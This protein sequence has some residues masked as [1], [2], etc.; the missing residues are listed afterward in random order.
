MAS[1]R[2]SRSLLLLVK[3]NQILQVFATDPHSII[4]FKAYCARTGNKLI[5]I[6]ELYDKNLFVFFIQRKEITSL[7]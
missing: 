2:R 6:D 3:S 5:Q 7:F 1:G 4:D